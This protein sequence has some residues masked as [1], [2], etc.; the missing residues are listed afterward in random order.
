MAL[1]VEIAEFFGLIS[2]FWMLLPL[3]IRQVFYFAMLVLVVIGFMKL[4][5]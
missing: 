5:W 3:L 2:S 1:P 4:L